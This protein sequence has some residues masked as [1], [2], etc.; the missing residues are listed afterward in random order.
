ML[1]V[2]GFV[3]VRGAASSAAV[4]VD[5]QSLCR[6][7]GDTWRGRGSKE[8]LVVALLIGRKAHRGEL[9]KVS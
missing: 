8:G 7:M 6:D 9:F 3:G 4:A 1:V 2:I 5:V